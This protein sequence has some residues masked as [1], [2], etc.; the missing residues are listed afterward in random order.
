MF[1][2]REEESEDE[3]KHEQHRRVKN[4]K[5]SKGSSHSMKST[6]DNLKKQGKASKGTAEV[7]SNL[8]LF[9]TLILTS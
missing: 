3:K 5:P 9:E 4:K 6:P 2:F 8:L 7:I 1:N